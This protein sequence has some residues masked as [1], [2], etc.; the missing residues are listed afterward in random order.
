MCGSSPYSKSQTQ[1]LKVFNT[2][3]TCLISNIERSLDLLVRYFNSQQA[4]RL[5]LTFENVQEVW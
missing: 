4:L 5:F 2:M 3:P 1:E